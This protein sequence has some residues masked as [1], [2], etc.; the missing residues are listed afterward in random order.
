MLRKIADSR[1]A[2]QA[3]LEEQ[4]DLVSSQ[5]TLKASNRRRDIAFEAELMR[6]KLIRSAV[7]ATEGL[8]NAG[9]RPCAW[10]FQLVSPSGRWYEAT[11]KRA[12]YYL[13]PL[14]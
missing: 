8:R 12:F 3:L 1:E 14:T 4:E 11:M 10:W 13:E 2:W 6:M 9:H 7:I 5:D